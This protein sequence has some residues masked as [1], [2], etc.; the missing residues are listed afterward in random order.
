M[1]LS[2]Q[3]YLLFLSAVKKQTKQ[4]GGETGKRQRGLTCHYGP[5]AGIELETLKSHG[6]RCSPTY[7][8]TKY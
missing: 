1:R 5:T 7:F 2:F 4:S 8:P 3:K 6:M